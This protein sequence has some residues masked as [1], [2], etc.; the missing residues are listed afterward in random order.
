M[1]K[2]DATVPLPHHFNLY[3]GATKSIQIDY[4]NLVG[5]VSSS[6]SSV[7]WDITGP[8]TTSNE[9]LSSNVASCDLVAGYEGSDVGTVTATLANGDV[10]ILLLR[11]RILDPDYI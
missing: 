4:T 9:S 11:I 10:V 8:V 1:I 6:V 2:L 7:S 3:K 5:K